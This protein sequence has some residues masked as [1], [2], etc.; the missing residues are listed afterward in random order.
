LT[1]V[2]LKQTGVKLVA[3]KPAQRADG[4]WQPTATLSG[5]R[6]KAGCDLIANGS[7][8]KRPLTAAEVGPLWLTNGERS[9]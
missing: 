2:V 5:K 4:L 3:A 6:F 9:R 1:P 8:S 7:P